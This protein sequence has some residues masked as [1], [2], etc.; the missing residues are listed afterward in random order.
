MPSLAYEGDWVPELA[1]LERYG[2]VV[3]PRLWKALCDLREETFKSLPW[4]ID[5]NVDRS[6]H[7]SQYA[8]ENQ[9]PKLYLDSYLNVVTESYFEG[10]PGDMFL[11]EK[12]C[13]PIAGLQPFVVF[14]HAGSLQVL[15][16]HGFER[17]RHLDQAYDEQHEVG[18]RLDALNR[19][20]AQIA[21][22]SPAE[23]H[24]VYFDNLSRML[25]NREK[26]LDMPRTLGLRLWERLWAAL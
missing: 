15:D 16:R 14:G 17:A 8:F 23:T 3:S 22:W 1:Q 11:T 12:I 24:E 19:S 21:S 20:L 10:E 7:T 4:A 25:H 13:K 6:G 18:P 9:I 5:I 2:A 26:L